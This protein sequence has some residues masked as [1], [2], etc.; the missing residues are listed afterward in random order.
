MAT[1]R[2]RKDYIG[3]IAAAEKDEKLTKGFFSKC[4]KTEKELK[5][6]FENQGFT[7]IGDDG[8]KQI[9]QAMKQ[10]TEGGRRLKSGKPP[11]PSGTHY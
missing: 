1:E 10:F 11:C 8:A 2:A 6:F 5:K 4:K 7:E 3:F 9:K